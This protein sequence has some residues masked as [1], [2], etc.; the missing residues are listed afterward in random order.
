MK[1]FIPK[2]WNLYHFFGMYNNRHNLP[3]KVAIFVAK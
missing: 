3:Q 2:K 1:T